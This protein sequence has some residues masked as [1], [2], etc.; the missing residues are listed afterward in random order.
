MGASARPS[1]L[2]PTSAPIADKGYD[3]DW[4]RAA[5]SDEG[6]ATCLPARRG[7]TNPARHDSRLY[8]KRRKIEN[9][10]ARLKQYRR[11]ASNH[12]S[13]AYTFAAFLTLVAI[14]DWL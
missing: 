7:R 4:V 6:I 3:A 11:I 14:R 2:P 8:R 9:L 10:F 5:L 13:R 1:A 12:K